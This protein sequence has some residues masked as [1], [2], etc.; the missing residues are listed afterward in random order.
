MNILNHHEPVI[1]SEAK[2]DRADPAFIFIRY[3]NLTGSDKT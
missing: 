2:N 1:L 3:R